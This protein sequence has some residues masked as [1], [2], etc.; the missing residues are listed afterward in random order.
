MKLLQILKELLILIGTYIVFEAEPESLDQVLF[1][2]TVFE[3]DIAVI[4]CTLDG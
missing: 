3:D 4:G 1:L 2:I